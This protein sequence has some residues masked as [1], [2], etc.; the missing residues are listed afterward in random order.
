L[1]LSTIKDLPQ[2]ASRRGVE[3]KKLSGLMR[4]ELDWIV[5]KALEKDRNRR[6]ATAN[7]LAADVQRYLHDEPVQA[8]PPSAWYRFG[9]FARR[10]KAALVTA[11]AVAL[12]VSL[13]V[14]VSTALVWRANQDLQHALQREQR[15]VYFQRITVAHRELSMGNLAAALRALDECP[16]DL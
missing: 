16:E 5:L 6:Y 8:C 2:I 13:T 3:P 11:T 12:A 14:A 10:N 4:G 15:E 7:A 9:K 1:R